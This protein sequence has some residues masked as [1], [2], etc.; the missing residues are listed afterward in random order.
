VT[1]GR[2]PQ[3]A[4]LDPA[5]G[6]G[7]RTTGSVGRCIELRELL[8]LYDAVLERLRIHDDDEIPF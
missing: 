6:S 2:G 5:R 1:S 7:R 4:A 3:A 8:D